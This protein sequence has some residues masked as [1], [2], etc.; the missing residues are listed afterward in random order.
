MAP[1][2][3]VHLGFAARL[4]SRTGARV[5]VKFAP[6]CV[7]PAY[8][9]YVAVCSAANIDQLD[10]LLA[11]VALFSSTAEPCTRRTSRS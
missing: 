1:L 6:L 9:S 5:A 7:A 10:L 3:S 4:A 11:V 2:R 8:L